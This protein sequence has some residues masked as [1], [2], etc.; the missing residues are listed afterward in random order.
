MGRTPL[1][2]DAIQAALA[3]L[4]GWSHNDDALSKTFEFGSFREA[5]SFFVRVSFEAEQ[6][7][8]HPEV[9]N[10]YNRVKLTLRTHDADGKVTEADVALA[11]AIESFSWL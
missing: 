3:S 6:L 10:V 8:H 1:T 7:N 5:V 2:N 4:K 9:E 11:R